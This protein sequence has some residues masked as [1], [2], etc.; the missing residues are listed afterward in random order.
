MES[1]EVEIGIEYND[2]IKSLTKEELVDL[3]IGNNYR[4]PILTRNERKYSRP[5]ITW[6]INKLNNKRDIDIRYTKE[7]VLEI[8]S[9]IEGLRYE[10]FFSYD[11]FTFEI[12]KP[13]FW[14]FL[15]I[16]FA[17]GFGWILAIT[18]LLW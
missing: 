1:R 6:G 10:N 4:A 18:M 11:Y 13:E 3:I 12:K 14:V 15:T 17:L 9:N 5:Q 7:D 8:L 2:Y 16:A